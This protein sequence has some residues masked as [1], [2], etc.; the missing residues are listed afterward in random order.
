M[1]GQAR[2]DGRGKLNAN[3]VETI[4]MPTTA[5]ICGLTT[6][7]TLDA[8]LAGGASHVGLNFFPPSPRNLS[9]DQARMLAARTPDRVHRV[10]VFVDPDDALLDMAIAAGRLDI[11]Q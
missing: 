3:R 7:E 4:L 6:I 2:H 1:R 9:A 11:L 5:K 10:G 8:A